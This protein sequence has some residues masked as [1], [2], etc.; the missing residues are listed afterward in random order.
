M[1]T[2]DDDGRMTDHCHTVFY[3]ITFGVFELKMQDTMFAIFNPFSCQ[4]FK[5]LSKTKYYILDIYL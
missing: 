2:T 4:L 3:I 1:A 5:V